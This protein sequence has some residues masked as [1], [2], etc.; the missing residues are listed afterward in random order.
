VGARL[1][2]ASSSTLPLD[3]LV[4]V[5]PAGQQLHVLNQGDAGGRAAAI[6]VA[7]DVAGAPVA[8]LPMRLNGDA[9]SDLVVLRAGRSSSV[10]VVLI[11]PARVF[12]VNSTAL[13]GDK[14]PFD[15]KCLDEFGKCTLSAALDQVTGLGGLRGQTKIDFEIGTGPRGTSSAAIKAAKRGTS[16]GPASDSRARTTSCAGTT[17]A[18]TRREANRGRTAPVSRWGATAR[19]VAFHGTGLPAS[20]T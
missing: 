14:D 1:I 4:V 13:T 19:S 20:G 5:D 9:L 6:R 3:D 16:P 10:A 2:R 11:D 7:W 8:S 12:E 17:S 15:R 18:S